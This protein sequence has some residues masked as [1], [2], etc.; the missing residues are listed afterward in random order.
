[1]DLEAS[2][3]V[4]LDDDHGLSNVIFASVKLMLLVLAPDW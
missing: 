1:L 2:A 3:N 4:S